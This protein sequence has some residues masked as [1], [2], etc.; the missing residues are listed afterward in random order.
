MDQVNGKTIH[1]PGF[2]SGERVSADKLNNIPRDT[3]SR[4]HAGSGLRITKSGG[5]VKLDSTN[6][7]VADT[8][9]PWVKTLPAIPTGEEECLAVYW[10]TVNQDSEATGDGQIWEANTGD[11]MWIPRQRFTDH[12]GT[13]GPDPL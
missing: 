13:P 4:V 2:Q 6:R 11:E 7:R 3:L 8:T 10:M 5:V 1:K 12:L 9:I